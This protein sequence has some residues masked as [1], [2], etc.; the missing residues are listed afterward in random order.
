[1]HVESVLFRAQTGDSTVKLLAPG[2]E[3][4]VAILRALKTVA[5]ADQS[6]DPR[7]LEFI[8]ACQA[9][10]NTT[11]DV[12]QLSTISPEELAE[13]VVDPE[14]RSAVIQRLI[15]VTL[16]DEAASPEEIVLVQQFAKALAVDEPVVDQMK[17]AAKGH[18]L[19]LAIDFFRRGFIGKPFRDSWQKHGFRGI[20]NTIRAFQG[21][22]TL[23]S[24]QKFQR[25]ESLPDGSLGRAY[26]DY[27]R[28]NSFPLPGEPKGAPEML[29]FHDLGHTLTGFSTEVA[30]EVQMAGFEAGYMGEDGFSVAALA[31]FAFHLGVELPN[32]QASR[33][34]FNFPSFESAWRL[35]QCLNLDLRSWDCWPHM[36]RSL[37]AVRQDLGLPAVIPPH[38][39]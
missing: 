23:E 11:C 3:A 30:G 15:V 37:S 10:M 39:L 5:Q 2:P 8:A 18:R 21:N 7:E 13:I 14:E 32:I 9:T 29:M 22:V 17:L 12:H 35:G 24:A 28:N 26:L 19:C 16:I 1:V 20:V 6:L 38:P 34:N 4:A 27:M 25:L 36:N 33:G 31:M